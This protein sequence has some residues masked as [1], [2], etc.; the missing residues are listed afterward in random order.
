METFKQTGGARIGRIFNVTW[1]FARIEV[2]EENLSVT[3]FGKRRKFQKDQ[4]LQLSRCNGLF[5]NGLLIT[6]ADTS[7]DL[8]FWSF[9]LDALIQNLEQRGYTLC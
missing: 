7:S 6:T 5:S 3:V 2:T 4:P 8:I 9:D 1:P